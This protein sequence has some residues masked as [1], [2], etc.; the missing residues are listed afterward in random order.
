[1]ALFDKSQQDLYFTINEST[2]KES[3]FDIFVKEQWKK[4]NEK[5]ILRYK[6]NN[7]ISKLLDGNYKFLAQV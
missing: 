1:M 3:N 6:F 4:A 7:T 2:P 5:G